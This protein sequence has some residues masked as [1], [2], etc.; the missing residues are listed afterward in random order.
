MTISKFL[1]LLRSQ[2]V[3]CLCL[4]LV[5]P[6]ATAFAQGQLTVSGVVSDNNGP[7]EGVS[8]EVKRGAVRTVTDATGQYRIQA[9]SGDTL[10]FRN[11]GYT[12]QEVAVGQNETINVLLMASTSSLDEVVVVGYGTQSRRN[13][14]GSVSKVD[15]AE[16][17]N[18]PNTNVTQA[19]R[20]R[21]AGVQFTDN[22]RPGQNGTILVRGP[23]SL[24]AGNN[25]LIILD[26]IFF[27]GSMIDINP[28][29]IESMEILKD[30]SAAAI[31]G[32]RAAN[33]VILITS[34]R[35]KT[36]KPQINLN[37]FY[38]LSDWAARMQLLTPE[39]YL[40]KSME[41]RRLRGIPFDPD[42]VSTYLTLT[43]AENYQ[44]GHII[45][46][47][48]MIAQQGRI[49]STDVS[50]SGNTARTNYYISA[51]M[52]REHG[53]IK[54]DNLRRMAFR[55]NLENK[56]T[57]WL[58]IG[59]NTMFSE[60]DQSGVPASISLA[61]RQSPYGTWFREDGSPTQFTVPEDQGASANPLRNNFLSENANFRNN[62]FA[63]FYTLINV[64]QIEG[65]KFRVNYS[66][67]YRWIRDYQATRNDVH[68]PQANTSSASKRNWMAQDW[69]LEN[70]LDYQFKLDNDHA[71]DITLMYGA[72]R[73][74]HET[75]TASADQLE[76]DAFGWDRLNVGEL[77][78]V[79]SYAQEV[80]GISSMARLNYRFKERYLFTLTA[81]RDGSSVF[82]ANNKYATFPSAAFAW[83]VSDE[84]F[85]QRADFVN[86]FKV[87]TSYGAVGNQA[88]SPYQSLSLS[89]ITRYVYGPESALGIYPS[90]ISNAD[91][92]WE[93]TYTANVAA[94]F[95]LFNNRIGGTVEWYNM[96]TRDLLVERSIPIMTGY[97]FIW[98][99]LGRVNNRG[100]ELTLNTVNI[101]KEKFEWNT[102]FVFSHNK[103]KIVS[104][105]GSDADGDGREDDDIGNRWFIG[106]PINVYYDFVFDGIYQE[107]DELPAGSQP[108]FARFRDLNGDG[109]IDADN[110]R[111]IIGQGGQPRYRWGITNNFRYNNFDLSIFINAMQGWLGTFNDLDFYSNSID[112]IRPG[113]M[114]DGGWW[115][116]ENRSNTRPS[117]E[118]RRSTLGHNWYLSRNFIRVQDVSLSYR[119]PSAFLAKN[120]LA[121]LNVYVSG[122]NLLTFTDWLGT[123]PES[124]STDRYPIARSYTLGFR[125][126]F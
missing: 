5:L 103:N 64:P 31:Y 108:G 60:N 54:D 104:L 96:D 2:R 17:E 48:D 77:Q 18:L 91:L 109:S 113:N 15:M 117:L 29:D 112:P 87:R 40:E 8:V 83:I 97:P 58:T 47:F 16:T 66:T 80:T 114:F 70:I 126:G 51:S 99:N 21:V 34:K 75:T 12:T 46:P 67:N 45:D 65:L 23:R 92:K 59:T 44:N 88:I 100:V 82:A 85:M 101:K 81:R 14:T 53:L 122:K 25:P 118:Y 33:G 111:T 124:I 95:E 27:N 32:S 7:L 36:E 93:T 28:N 79:S 74:G 1:W 78:T 71:F 49:F 125:L 68:L 90:N 123:N 3:F 107:G 42:N 37:T 72:N 30:A 22:G 35:G 61:S 105:Y 84:G 24:S 4:A 9:N 56:I 106:Q 110:D 94:D 10:V 115:T 120:R 11:V 6:M 50:L 121:N 57:D 55:V 19:L 73:D 116:P 13:V 26:G 63:N 38:G 41:I 89:S 39:R 102:N 119:F 76:F 62:L 69:V 86:F 20:G 43:E 52:A 98:T